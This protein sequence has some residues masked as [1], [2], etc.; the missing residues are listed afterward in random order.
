MYLQNQHKKLNPFPRSGTQLLCIAAFLCHTKD[1]PAHP[2]FLPLDK[3]TG[4][5]YHFR[6]RNLLKSHTT[7]GKFDLNF[8]LHWHHPQQQGIKIAR[9]FWLKKTGL[10]DYSIKKKE[11]RRKK[12]R[13]Y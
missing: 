6:V 4:N 9:S 10:M 12:E 13:G 7:P 5:S 3:G 8:C 2:A 1:E 11:K